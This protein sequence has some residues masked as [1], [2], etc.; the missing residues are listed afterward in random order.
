[1]HIW[2]VVLIFITIITSYLFYLYFKD[3]DKRKL[4]FAIAFLLSVPAFFALSFQFVTLNTDDA[5]VLWYNIFTLSPLPFLFAVFIAANENV[6][7]VKKYDKV[8][9]SF[10]L[11]SVICMFLVFIPFKLTAI[12][13]II[14]ISISLEILAVTMYQF[15]KTREIENLYFICY[16]ITAIAAGVGFTLE[17]GYFSSFAFLVGYL[18]ISLLFVQPKT[19]PTGE[20]KSIKNYFTI[21]KELKTIEERYKQLF[22]AIPDAITVVNK[23]GTI[24]DVNESAAENLRMS[25]QDLIGL[26]IHTLLPPEVDKQRNQVSLEALKTGIIQENEDER[27]QMIFHNLFIPIDISDREK[28]VLVIS[29]NITDEKKMQVE[30]EERINDLRNTELATLNIMEDMQETVENL[31]KARKEIFDK[32]K[33]LELARDQLADL[34]DHLEQKIEER[35]KDIE[36]L[37]KQKDAFID[38]LGHDLKHP[39]GP[40]INLLPLLKKGETDE[41][42]QKIIEV[43]QRNVAYMKRLVIR[44][45]QLAKLNAPST[46]FNFKTIHFNELIEKSIEKNTGLFNQYHVEIK[47]QIDDSIFLKADSLQIEEVLENLLSNAVKYGAENGTVTISAEKQ[48]EQMALIS[49]KD[50]GKGMNQDQLTYA[51]HE[52]YKADESRH[53][54][55]DTGLGLSICKRI[56]EKHGGKIWA[57]SEGIGKGTSIFFTLPLVNKKINEETIAA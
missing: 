38:Q 12:P 9:Y 6:F 1:S 33:D 24:L 25:K 34:N 7:E 48:D 53:D 10:L 8:F 50:T 42:K 14:R 16:I 29:K 22:N 13:T 51:F 52:F 15:S 44:T 30:R 49:I 17:Y 54:F 36:Q 3:R 32:N 11:L 21:E 28:Q 20:K 4:L 31:E 19:T 26:K 46:T 39:L 41:K 27:N 5:S 55:T 57:E 47:K 40:F 23:D 2:Y 45:V 56:V 37:L 35:T 18:F 43:L